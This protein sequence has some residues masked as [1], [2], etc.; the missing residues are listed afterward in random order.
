[1]NDVMLFGE[2]WNGEILTI[3]NRARAIHHIPVKH[4]TRTVT[5]FIT[6]Y[7]SDSGIPYLIG[8]SELEPSQEDI[9]KAIVVYSPRGTSFPKY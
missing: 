1:M 7:I 9:E 2:G 5:F 8:I 6:T 4:E 3:A